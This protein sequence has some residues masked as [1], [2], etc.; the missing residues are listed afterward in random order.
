MFHPSALRTVI[1]DSLSEAQQEAA[2]GRFSDPNILHETDVTGTI[3]YFTK[4]LSATVPPVQTMYI[5]LTNKTY[6]EKP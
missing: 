5:L 6:E 2:A 1:F 3:S 4:D